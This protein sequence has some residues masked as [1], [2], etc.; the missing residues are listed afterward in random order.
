[1]AGRLERVVPRQLGFQGEL[2]RDARLHS[3]RQWSGRNGFAHLLLMQASLPVSFWSHVG[4]WT[5]RIDPKQL[6]LLDVGYIRDN[7]DPAWKGEKRVVFL[8]TIAAVRIVICVTQ[9]KELYEDAN[10]SLRDLMLYSHLQHHNDT[11][12]K[13]QE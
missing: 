9:K 7:V 5:A 1:M 4:E 8:V 12:I 10:F 2:D 3:L 13:T 6:V 11:T